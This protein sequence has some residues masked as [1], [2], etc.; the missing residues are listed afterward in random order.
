MV[1]TTDGAKTVKLDEL[2]AVPP[3]VVTEIVPVVAVVGIVAE[4]DVAL[5]TVNVVAATLLNLTAVAF[6][7]L[8]PTKA[9]TFA[10]GPEVGVKDVI[11]GGGITV[12]FDGLG[13]YAPG[14]PRAMT[15]VVAPVGIVNVID[16]G[17]TIVN[18]VFWL[19]I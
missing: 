19:L 11:V 13:P 12:K 6:E 2:V 14:D 7:K 3:G 15:P 5:F 8:V 10:G 1:V 9:T 18:T 16:V 4:I 17:E